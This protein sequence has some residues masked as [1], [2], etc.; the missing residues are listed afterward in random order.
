ME[1]QYMRIMSP[2]EWVPRGRLYLVQAPP[3]VLLDDRVELFCPYLGGLCEDLV[4]AAVAY[5]AHLYVWEFSRRLGVDMGEFNIRVLAKAFPQLIPALL[6]RLDARFTGDN[7][8]EWQAVKD[9]RYPAVVEK[10]DVPADPNCQLEIACAVSHAFL[11]SDPERGVKLLTKCPVL[12]K[13][14][15]GNLYGELADP[16][17]GYGVIFYPAAYF[18]Q[19]A[20]AL[21]HPPEKLAACTSS[22]GLTRGRRLYPLALFQYWALTEREP[23]V[24][25]LLRGYPPV[26]LS[27]R[28]IRC[29]KRFLYI[30]KGD[31]RFEKVGPP[32]PLKTPG[33]FTYEL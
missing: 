16:K 5:N 20:K 4:R 6:R 9:G 23:L 30:I 2:R 14:Y 13:L 7:A 22:A 28:N 17:Y 29:G 10:W 11:L 32:H 19:V 15:Q 33:F 21:P 12:A 18:R 31:R 25:Y 8:E 1:L 26:R 3:V 24:D 27:C